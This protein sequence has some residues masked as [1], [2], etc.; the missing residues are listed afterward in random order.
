MAF[1][2]DGNVVGRWGWGRQE[3]GQGDEPPQ[4]LNLL[5]KR[6]GEGGGGGL[7]PGDLTASD[8]GTPLLKMGPV[9]FP[10]KLVKGCWDLRK[11]SSTQ[12]IKGIQM[13]T[14]D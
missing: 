12:I 8:P 1:S 10:A 4:T 7:L 13:K 11:G 3:S 2:E 6:G 9:S 14:M 5:G